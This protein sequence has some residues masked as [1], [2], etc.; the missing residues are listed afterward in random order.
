MTIH[1]VLW[2]TFLGA[3]QG[4]QTSQTNALDTAGDTARSRSSLI[5]TT[6]DR[7]YE[8][9][10]REAIAKGFSPHA[11]TKLHADE[12]PLVFSHQFQHYDPEDPEK[13]IYY[14]YKAERHPNVTVLSAEHVAKCTM[15]TNQTDNHTTVRLALPSTLAID[16]VLV[17]AGGC[18][19]HADGMRAPPGAMQHPHPRVAHCLRA[20]RHAA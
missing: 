5:T 14:Q 13:L 4:F 3:A 16:K 8:A 7:K 20:R 12:D 15:A 19:V 6:M 11:D 1:R 17:L 9:E 18:E 10:H 2:L